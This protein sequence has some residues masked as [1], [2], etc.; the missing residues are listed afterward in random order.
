MD[1]LREGRQEG[2][3]GMDP[4]TDFQGALLI[5]HADTSAIAKYPFAS[6]DLSRHL[7]QKMRVCSSRCFVKGASHSNR[8]LPKTD[9]F[10]KENTCPAP[11]SSSDRVWGWPLAKGCCCRIFKTLREPGTFQ[12]IAIVGHRLGKEGSWALCWDCRAHLG[13]SVSTLTLLSGE[14]RAGTALSTSMVSF[15]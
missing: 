6:W 13:S 9:A 1:V 10:G 4:Q 2:R 12:E 7:P 14:V 15:F 3:Q 5:Q 8:E 11:F